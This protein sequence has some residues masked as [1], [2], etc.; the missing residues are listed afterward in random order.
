MM[1]SSNG[2]TAILQALKQLLAAVIVIEH[3]VFAASSYLL[4]L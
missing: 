4:P 1:L 2:L 3:I